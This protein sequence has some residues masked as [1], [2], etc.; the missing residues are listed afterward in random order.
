MNKIKLTWISLLIMLFGMTA[1]ISS[2]VA[3]TA[4]EINIEV[5]ATLKRFADQVGGGQ[6]FLNKANGVLVMP[7]VIK[8]GFIVGGKYGEG[9][10]RVGGKT[11]N[12][13]AVAGASIGLLAGGQSQAIVVVFLDDEALKK[14]RASS[15]WEAGVDGSIA[16]IDTGAAGDL[17][18]K[19]ANKPI[20]GFVMT[21]KGLMADV[22]LA[23]SK[24][25][26]IVR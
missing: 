5:N 25:T 7:N 10:L 3:A 15:G 18:T 6:E 16:L 24:F 26:K 19:T 8:A 21:N 13:Y 12:Y 11:V 9:A 17:T 23:G 4:E 2:S 14:F 1:G 22:S 20:V